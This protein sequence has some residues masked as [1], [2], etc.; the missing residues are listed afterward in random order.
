[1]RILLDAGH[2]KGINKGS[3]YFE[4][5]NNFYYSLELQKQ[6]KLKGFS[7][8]L[9]RNAIEENQ[10]IMK[11]SQMGNGYDLVLSIHSNGSDDPK[12]KGT[13]I[14]DNTDNPNTALAEKLCEATAKFFDHP[15]RGVIYKKKSTGEN[16]WGVLRDN[17]A[18]SSML[19]EIGFHTNLED[20]NTFLK[21]HENLAKLHA[22][23]INDHYKEKVEPMDVLR[24][25][26]K[27]GDVFVLHS[28]L[29][30]KGYNLVPDGSFGPA[31]RNAV[32]AFQ[33]TNNLT[34]DAI[35]GPQTWNALM[36]TT[37]PKEDVITS[38]WFDKQVKVIKIKKDAVRMEV[39]V[40]RQPTETL[41]QM[42]K[43]LFK[44]P[45]LMFNAG[46]FG[47]LNGVTLSYVKSF[48]KEITEGVYSKYAMC[49]YN[50]G[51]IDLQ[52][53]YW[54]KQ[55][56]EWENIPHAIGAQPTLVI[57]KEIR[58][59][60][61]GLDYG[62]IHHLHPRLAYGVDD[63]FLYVLIVHGRN[64]TKGYHG[65]TLKALANLGMKLGITHLINMDGGDS[66]KVLNQNGIKMD[67]NPKNRAVDTMVNIYLK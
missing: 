33:R 43:R 66:I 10:T 16:F 13:E 39:E 40:A 44:K 31:T 32:M 34:V 67:D 8:D 9:I 60:L 15:N 19:F 5:N 29:N 53:M 21:S 23:I 45:L 41:Y 42:Y 49:Q 6:L 17:K 51:K 64:S 4:G 55:I 20:C 26:A 46:M 56:G 7:V 57:N 24:Y 35:V 54:A 36:R 65:M 28:L 50:N 3:C 27:G 52:G 61:T 1:M 18:T 47:M 22:E 59:D 14:F 48:G 30:N 37:K 11:R 12:V 25:G 58:M 63:N 38:Y 62:F 2:T